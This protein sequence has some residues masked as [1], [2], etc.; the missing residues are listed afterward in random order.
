MQLNLL[1]MMAQ[2]HITQFL[3]H[4][5]LLVVMKDIYS[6]DVF[7]EGEDGI[8]DFVTHLKDEDKI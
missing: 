5:R 2:I 6:N 3:T 4:F 8:Y 7:K 1:I